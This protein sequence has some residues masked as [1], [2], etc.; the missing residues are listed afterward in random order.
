MT[1]IYTRYII[2]YYI[3][4]ETENCNT[5]I[6]LLSFYF[7]RFYVRIV[8]QKYILLKTARSIDWH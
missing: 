7:Q 3:N 2:L 8:C 6:F 1:I 5:I 4:F